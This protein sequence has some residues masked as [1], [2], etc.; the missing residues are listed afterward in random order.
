MNNNTGKVNK[1]NQSNFKFNPLPQSLEKNKNKGQTKFD[2]SEYFT[3]CT[4]IS[5][6]IDTELNTLS[7]T[8]KLEPAYKNAIKKPLKMNTQL[9]NYNEQPVYAA[10]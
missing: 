3:T 2:D 1:S 9:Q 4:G 8:N 7:T 10:K 6:N 5:T